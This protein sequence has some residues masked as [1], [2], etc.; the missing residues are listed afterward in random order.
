MWVGGSLIKGLQDRGGST[1][2]IQNRNPFSKLRF[3][4]VNHHIRQL[5]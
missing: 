3:S 4:F 1:F 5:V 2:Q